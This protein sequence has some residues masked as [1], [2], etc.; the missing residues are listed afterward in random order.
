ML[1]FVVMSAAMV[2]VMSKQPSLTSTGPAVPP[3]VVSQSIV[4]RAPALPSAPAVD[5]WVAIT[6][7]PPADTW[8][9]SATAALAFVHELVACRQDTQG[10][11]G[12]LFGSCSVAALTDGRLVFC[13]DGLT[14]VRIRPGEWATIPRED[15]ETDLRPVTKAERRQATMLM[16][17]SDFSPSRLEAAIPPD[18]RVTGSATAGWE[19]RTVTHRSENSARGNSIS[20]T[21]TGAGAAQIYTWYGCGGAR[22]TNTTTTTTPRMPT[23]PG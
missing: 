7:G 6:P 16:M 19:L 15:L 12:D 18:A 1:A 21:A 5:P 17:A 14:L 4:A 23:D 10:I 8:L 13:N 11:Y 2:V 3:P 20:F 22:R 9:D